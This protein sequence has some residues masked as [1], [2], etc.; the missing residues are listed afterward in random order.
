MLHKHI[1]TSGYKAGFIFLIFVFLFAL[2]GYTQENAVEYQKTIEMAD[3]YF[4]KGDYIN[5][6]ASYQIAVRLAPDD[7]YP[8]DRLQQ[9]L[10]MIKV[11]MYQNSLYQQKI[12]L[13]DDLLG[14]NDLEAALKTYQEALVILPGDSYASGRVQEISNNMVGNKILGENYQKSIIKGDQLLQEG[15]LENALAEY[16]NASSLK[17]AESYPKEKAAQVE[18]MLAD[19]RALTGT[20]E[21]LLQEADVAI[22]HNK[23]DEAISNLEQAIKLKPD[24]NLPKTKLAEAQKL[25]IAWD[26]YSKII[27]DADNLYISKDFEEAK[28]K[29]LQAES[30]KPADEYPKRMIEK[31]D[32]A[33]MDIAKADRSSYEVTIALADKLFNEQDYER[34]I[35]EYNNALRFKPE[36]EYAKQRITDINNALNLRKTQEQAY[37]Q[38]IAKADKLYNDQLYEDARG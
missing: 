23:Y 15:N 34:A 1:M 10:D 25:K 4:S 8:K 37:L 35:V 3:G 12:Q 29:Y 32:I 24:E 19:K 27:S 6:K 11:Q 14:K 38:S 5:A 33:L 13:A 7:Q 36:E 26:S 30:I 31:I 22:S 28:E 2:S 20:Y 16:R 17:P 9:S 18:K 21:N